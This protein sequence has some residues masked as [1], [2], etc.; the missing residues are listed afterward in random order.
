MNHVLIVDDEADI[1]E[2]L[3][4]ILSEEDYTHHH[5]RHRRRSA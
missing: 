2:S 5:R 1:R 4:A 3:Q